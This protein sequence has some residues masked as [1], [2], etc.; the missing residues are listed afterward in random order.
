MCA[1]DMFISDYLFS[2][3]YLV[4]LS[5]KLAVSLRYIVSLIL[6]VVFTLFLS[7]SRISDKFDFD[8]TLI[9]NFYFTGLS[10]LGSFDF[11]LFS[12]YT[13]A[14]LLRIVIRLR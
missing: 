4:L 7:F 13:Y 2:E 1:I 14:R 5:T 6:G 8:P 11:S 3:K 9:L 10:F 12:S